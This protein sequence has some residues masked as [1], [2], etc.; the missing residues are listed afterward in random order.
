[1]TRTLSVLLVLLSMAACSVASDVDKRAEH[2]RPDAAATAH[3]DEQSKAQSKQP[4]VAEPAPEAAEPAQVAAQP[5]EV[6]PEAQPSGA[7]KALN[8]EVAAIMKVAQAPM[9]EAPVTIGPMSFRLLKVPGEQPEPA[10][11]PGT[12]RYRIMVE[13][14]L[15]SDA[16]RFGERVRDVLGRKDGWGAIGI[17][18]VPVTKN[19]DITVLLA[20]PKTVDRLCRPLNTAGT[21]SCAMY[22]RA[23]LNYLRWTTGAKTWGDDVDGY[24][25]YLINHEVGHLLGLLHQRCPKPGEPAPVMLPQT[26]YLQ[27]CL[28]NGTPTADEMKR[29]KRSLRNWDKRRMKLRKREIPPPP[30]K[31]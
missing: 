2:Q 21:L 23:N 27:R 4:E 6:A 28:P 17:D 1:M 25:D 20:N 15:E 3:E 19:H 12:I 29:L 8:E 22:R 16:A 31:R 5:A 13:Q 14:G 18:F 26:K 9:V 10:L 11:T 30:K 7:D 24:R